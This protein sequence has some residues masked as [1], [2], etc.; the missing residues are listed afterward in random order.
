VIY[1]FLRDVANLQDKFRTHNTLFCFDYG[2]SLRAKTYPAYKSARHKKYKEES[3]VEHILRQEFHRQMMRLRKTLLPKIGFKNILFQRGLEADDMI[4]LA[5]MCLDAD[6]EAIIISA[7]HD[8]YQCLAANVSMYAPAQKKLTTLQ[9]FHKE[10]GVMPVEWAMVKAMAGCSS[11]S[12]R[13]V[14]G[15]GEKTAIKFLRRELKT[16]HKTFLRIASPESQELIKRNME[17]TALPHVANEPFKAVF[18]E[19]EIDEDGW[20]WV[21][22]ELGMPSLGKKPPFG[23]TSGRTRNGKPFRKGFGI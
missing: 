11:D 2:K 22:K 21:L 4:A 16:T 9:S 6:D 12:V 15:V 23:A 10:Y 14:E 8:L 20:A 17:L 5:A 13:G 18:V 1:G 7:D 19:D 3:D